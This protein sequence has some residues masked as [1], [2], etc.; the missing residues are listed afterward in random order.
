MFLCS[1]SLTKLL[2]AIHVTNLNDFRLNMDSLHAKRMESYKGLIYTT[3]QSSTDSSMMETGDAVKTGF[4]DL[5]QLATPQDIIVPFKSELIFIQ[6]E[7]GVGSESEKILIDA[8]H[9][10]PRFPLVIYPDSY[11]LV[12]LGDGQN[13]T[14]I[15]LEQTFFLP[16]LTQFSG[17]TVKELELYLR[18]LLLDPSEPLPADMPQDAITSI[19]QKFNL[20]YIVYNGDVLLSPRPLIEEI[21]ISNN[22][23]CRIVYQVPMKGIVF[24]GK[25]KQ[26]K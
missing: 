12:D 5:V 11:A 18:Y 19:V 22:I 16:H 21:E 23:H 1:G 7:S 4:V 3:S 13:N 26:V 24:F 17:L 14:P 9:M 6:L 10:S 20:V 2:S 15:M 8:Y 25:I